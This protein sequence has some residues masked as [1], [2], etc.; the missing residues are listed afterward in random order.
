MYTHVSL[1]HVAV[2]L[3]HGSISDSP[4]QR[5]EARKLFSKHDL[6]CSDTGFGLL[7]FTQALPQVILQPPLKCSVLIHCPSFLIHPPGS[8]TSSPP[9][10]PRWNDVCKPE[11][12]A[13]HPVSPD[14]AGRL[15]RPAKSGEM[16]TMLRS[17]VSKHASAG[18]S[19]AVADPKSQIPPLPLATTELSNNI[20]LLR[21]PVRS[22]APGTAIIQKGISA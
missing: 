5:A 19:P 3:I 18:A 2:S 13:A 8:L 15:K 1:I 12:P 4:P 10:S 17:L 21:S 22:S 14:F 16:G 7:D 11:R 6:G 20:P 9:G